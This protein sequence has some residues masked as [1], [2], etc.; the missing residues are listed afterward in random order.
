MLQLSFA[1]A[2]LMATLAYGHHL[3]FAHH[4]AGNSIARATVAD[5]DFGSLFHST[6]GVLI[7]SF[8]LDEEI[9]I[10]PEEGQLRRIRIRKL[11]RRKPIHKRIKKHPKKKVELP[12]DEGLETGDK[13]TEVAPT[14]EPTTDSPDTKVTTTTPDEESEADQ[15]TA[16]EETE[17]Y[18]RY[19]GSRRY[20]YDRYRRH[21]YDRYRRHDYD[22]YRR[23]GYDRYRRYGSGRRYGRSY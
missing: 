3:Q 21:D 4:G 16:P 18:R 14:G 13:G 2:L 20:D 5:T 19:G 9:E 22:R 17:L 11:L 23:Y 6:E 12:I 15:D 8:F 7:P 1:G 10:T